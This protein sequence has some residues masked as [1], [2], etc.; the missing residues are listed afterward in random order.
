M[1]DDGFF[2]NF[3][4]MIQ[5]AAAGDVPPYYIGVM[6]GTSLDGIDAVVCEFNDDIDEPC[7]VLA[8]K[9]A[10]FNDDLRARLLSLANGGNDLREFGRLGVAYAHEVAD[11]VHQLL[12]DAGINAHEVAAIGCHGQTVWHAPDEGVSLQVLDPNVLAHKTH[13]CVVSDFRRRD[14]AA[15]GQGAPLIPAFHANMFLP[16]MAQKND[17]HW[18]VLNLGGIANITHIKAL[19]GQIELSGGDIGVANLLMDGWYQRHFDGLFDKNGEMAKTGAVN[20]VL[21]DALLAHPFFKKPDPK[22]TGREDFSMVWLDDILKNHATSAVDVQATLLAFSVQ[23][24]INHLKKHPPQALWLCGG[25]ALNGA[26]IDILKASVEDIQIHTTDTLG[27]YPTHLEAAGFAW[28]AK[29]TL[30]QRAAN[31]PSITGASVPVV[32]GQVC[33]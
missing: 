21:L 17:T 27:I 14:M 22:S 4:D 16:M 33:F 10:P 18:A 32:L 6:S 8:H 3:K 1:F 29:Q 19:D 26:L 5:D 13:L 24:I 31:I 11:L 2:A 15:G 20:D 9:Y 25:G 23:I 30:E 7:T 28:L 12:S